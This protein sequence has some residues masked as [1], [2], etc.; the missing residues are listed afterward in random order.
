MSAL[1]QVR[2]TE[3]KP[4]PAIAAIVILLVVV[5]GGGVVLVKA[6]TG[7]QTE[8]ATATPAASNSS[9]DETDAQSPAW[10]PQS[11]P[12]DSAI[13]QRNL[14]RPSPAQ[15]PVAAA[16]A[17]TSPAHALT[18]PANAGGPRPPGFPGGSAGPAL[19][20]TGIVKVGDV[21]YALLE[22]AALGVGLYTPVGGSA[23]GSRLLEIGTDYVVVETQGKT[24]RLSL[25]NSKAEVVVAAPV[26]G[27]ATGPAG[28]APGAAPA[29]PGAVVLPGTPPAGPTTGA[30][31]RGGFSRGRTGRVGGGGGMPPNFGNFQRPNGG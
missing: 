4:G 20:C 28:A 22:S 13:V 29:T 21:S 3:I 7:R 6:L 11:A 26:P 1:T 30:G 19:Y 24:Q 5:G 18:A 15:T 2:S 17:T 9:A 12:A 31:A 16:A 23:Y 25:Q 10:S 27:S 8:T 14:F